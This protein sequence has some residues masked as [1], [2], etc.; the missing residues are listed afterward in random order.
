MLTAHNPGSG[1]YVKKGHF[2]CKFCDRPAYL[3]YIMNIV[4]VLNRYN[5]ACI[6]FLISLTLNVSEGKVY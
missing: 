3:F 2:T 6:A 5:M 4:Q 1:Q